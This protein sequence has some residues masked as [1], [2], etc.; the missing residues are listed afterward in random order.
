MS[1]ILA[2]GSRGRQISI[3]LR[4]TWSLKWVPGQPGLCRETLSQKGQ[5]KGGKELARQLRALTALLEVL[6]S[7]PSHRMGSD[8]LFWCVWRE[9][10]CTHI[11]KIKKKIK[12]KERKQ[13]S[14]QAKGEG[15]RMLLIL[16]LVT[17]Y[18]Q[19]WLMQLG[20]GCTSL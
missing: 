1:L 13:A 12:K 9:W 11:H 7:I 8:A 20:T 2:L 4:P 5:R 14:K 15:L 6:S 16:G 18:H 10:Q 3:K 17:L 19:K